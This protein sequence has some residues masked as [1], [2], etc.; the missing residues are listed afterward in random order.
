MINQQT[1]FIP[2]HQSFHLYN[3]LFITSLV[4]SLLFQSRLIPSTTQLICTYHSHVPFFQ[5]LWF[6]PV[7]H[8]ISIHYLTFAISSLKCP[9]IQ[10]GIF[11]L[12]KPNKSYFQPF[13]VFFIRYFFALINLIIPFFT[14]N[15]FFSSNVR[16]NSH[17]S[18]LKHVS[19]LNPYFK[20]VH[21]SKYSIQK[22]IH[23][24][25]YFWYIWWYF[26]SLVLIY[27]VFTETFP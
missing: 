3:D 19:L 6:I 13:I 20:P 25:V 21:L 23:P 15:H 24:L 11:R 9:N 12:N 5:V 4:F 8:L 27:P 18:Y 26:L 17:D 10:L 1:R 16:I 2:S 22:V 14:L 7:H